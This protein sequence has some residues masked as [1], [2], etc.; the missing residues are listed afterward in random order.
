MMG[1][2]QVAQDCHVEDAG[3][4]EMC[5]SDAL[6]RR[7]KKHHGEQQILNN[8]RVEENTGLE[9]DD[10]SSC[11]LFDAES[12]NRRWLNLFSR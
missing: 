1:I 9:N 4:K 3:W 10:M 11:G 8:V 6:Y 5:W 7:R 12:R 2:S